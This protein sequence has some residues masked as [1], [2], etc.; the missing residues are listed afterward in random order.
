M[1]ACQGFG[2]TGKLRQL[3]ERMDQVPHVLVREVDVACRFLQVVMAQQFL[4]GAEVGS[5]IVQVRGETVPTMPLP[6]LCRMLKFQGP[7]TGVSATWARH[8]FRHPLG[9]L[10]G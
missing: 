6:G 4:N 1:A 2:G 3:I 9:T 5:R 8:S 10:E 7:I